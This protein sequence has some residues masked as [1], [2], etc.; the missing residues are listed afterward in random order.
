LV[1][2]ARS[3]DDGRKVGPRH[4]QGVLQ[5]TRSQD[6]ALLRLKEGRF[7]GDQFDFR[8]LQFQAVGV[9]GVEPDLEARGLLLQ[10]LPD[11]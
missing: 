11:A 10:L 9:T 8:V 5:L 2:V 3:P 4:L 1:A 6:G 7:A